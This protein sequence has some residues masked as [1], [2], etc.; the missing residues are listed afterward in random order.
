MSTRKSTA[1]AKLKATS[2]EKRTHLWK[3]H[4]ENLRGKLPKVRN[5]PIRKIICK[6]LDIKLGQFM[7]EGLDSGLRKIK[8]KKAARLDEIPPEV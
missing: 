3:R 4:I 5:K 7:Q 6:H 1:K 2:Q 8:N